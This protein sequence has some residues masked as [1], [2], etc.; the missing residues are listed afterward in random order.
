MTDLHTEHTLTQPQH[1]AAVA[2]ALE[3]VRGRIASAATSAGRNPSEITLVAVSKT[4]P[5]AAVHAAIAAGQ[6]DFGENRVEEALPKIGEIR[7]SRLDTFHP[8]AAAVRWH[9]IGH[10]QSRKVKNAVGHFDLIHSVDSLKL[11]AAINQRVAALRAT[12]PI[13]SP[14]SLISTP[15]SLLLECN[16]RG[17]ESKS[18]FPVAGWEQ[19]AAVRDSFVR[20]VEQIARLPNLRLCGLMTIAPIVDADHPDRARPIFASLRELRELLRQQFPQI[21]WDHLSMGMSDDFETAIAEGATL[22][23]LGRAIFG[24]RTYA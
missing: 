19:D 22:V 16:I 5:A 1:A 8:E 20:D 12:P 2:R 17:E 14:P 18:G 9:L 7:D 10:L 24:E 23:R 3:H 15:Q 4:F 6:R 21:A 11:A 13:S